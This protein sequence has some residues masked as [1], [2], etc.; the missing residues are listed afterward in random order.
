[1]QAA[2]VFIIIFIVVIVVIFVIPKIAG[3]LIPDGFGLGRD[4]QKGAQVVF[5]SDDG[6]LTWNGLS[7][8][9]DI[10]SGK[11]NLLFAIIDDQ[12]DKKI[13]V[14][15][16]GRG[17]YLSEDMG[18]TFK[19]IS[20]EAVGLG[21]E[22]TVYKLV[23]GK[24]SGQRSIYLAVFSNGLG[25]IIKWDGK[26]FF[27]RIYLAP[28]N[29][30][31]VFSLAQNPFNDDLYAGTAQ[32]G[33]LVSENYGISWKILRWFP[34]AISTIEI[35][36]K[37]GIMLVYTNERKL[38]RSSD[39]GRTWTEVT[40]NLNKLSS[41]ARD[42]KTIIFHPSL[43]STVYAGTAFGLIKSED[44]GLTWSLVRTIVPPQFLPIESVAFSNQNRNLILLGASSQVHRSLDSGD[45]WNAVQLPTSK[46]VGVII[47]NYNND[48][49]IYAGIR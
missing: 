9:P 27:E 13:F 19:L 10:S 25:S 36:P 46:R 4:T 21:Q 23:F 22:S 44:N 37:N 18:E 29:N 20:N 11:D 1:M 26:D 17:L 15:F 47:V 38:F 6:G 32:G 45:S 33:F 5:K 24:N 43:Q 2:I 30:I 14:S 49:I 40:S 41:S 7:N 16:L 35:N 31:G 28:V 8:L 48:K 39:N 3:P 34:G 42:I 12:N